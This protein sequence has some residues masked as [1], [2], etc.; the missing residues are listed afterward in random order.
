MTIRDVV[1][2]GSGAA[3]SSAAFHL[4]NANKKVTIVE[5]DLL[6][7]L[8]PCGG[9]IAA[10]VQELFPFSLEPIIEEVIKKVEFSWCLSDKVIAN[11]PGSAPFWIVRRENLDLFF[12]LSKLLIKELNY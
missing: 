11:L 5:K 3:G 12:S 1:I 10:S 9:G 4:A 7:K 6:P 8:K 2:I